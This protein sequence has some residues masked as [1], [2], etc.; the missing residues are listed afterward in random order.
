MFNFKSYLISSVILMALF[1]GGCQNSLENDES[2]S[3]RIEK[4][5]NLRIVSLS[6]TLTETL[7]A[8]NQGKNVVGVDITSTYPQG[9][10]EIDKLG[11][12]SSIK[13]EGIISLNPTHLFLEAGTI[14]E[15]VIGQV[16]SAGIKVVSIEREISIQG[17]KD[18]IQE[19]AKHLDITPDK[20]IFEK[21]DADL[22]NVF[23]LKEK[24][25]ILFIYGRGAGNLMVAGDGTPL[26]RVIE[27]AGGQNAVSGFSDYKPLS[28]E[29][30][31]EANPDYILMFSSSKKSL[32]G[33]D[34]IIEIPGVSETIAGKSK[35]IIFMDGQLLSGFGP[36]VGEAIATLNQKLQSAIE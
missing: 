27:L 7:F 14:D 1:M 33:V 29:V 8:L 3:H 18:F 21:I 34:G 4:E 32:N 12:T 25:K 26:K 10:E 19:V 6:G 9:V 22:E 16:K 31:I 30:I 11:H 36:R 23:A 20:S 24:P 28:N 5:E 13:A 17:T 35:N 15:T 2:D